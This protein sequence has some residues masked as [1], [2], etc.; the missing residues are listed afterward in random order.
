VNWCT[1][2]RGARVDAAAPWIL[3]GRRPALLCAVFFGDCPARLPKTFHSRVPLGPRFSNAE[4]QFLI[5]LF[6][7]SRMVLVSALQVSPPHCTTARRCDSSPDFPRAFP[8]NLRPAGNTVNSRQRPNHN[9]VVRSGIGLR[10][11]EECSVFGRLDL[12]HRTAESTLKRVV[13]CLTK[14]LF[15]NS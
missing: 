10:K 14:S 13:P 5:A 1:L 9:L 7:G 6:G 4:T 11:W 12:D 8:R 15:A 3:Y 2:A